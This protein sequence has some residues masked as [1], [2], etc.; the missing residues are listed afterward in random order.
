MK[1]YNAIW[2]LPGGVENYYSALQKILRHVEEQEPLQDQMIEDYKAL[3][4]TVNKDHVA[5]TQMLI[6]VHMGYVELS[7]GKY[8]LTEDGRSF[9]VQ[10]DSV[11]VYRRLEETHIGFQEI[12]LGLRSGCLSS[13]EIHAILREQVNP[14]WTT[15]AQ[16]SYRVNWLRSL[17][18][19]E[20]D[21]LTFKLMESGRKLS[22]EISSSNR[23]ST[24]RPESTPVS[25]KAPSAA[26]AI[27]AKL[28]DLGT[29]GDKWAEF[30][31]V[32][33]EAFEFLGFT[34]TKIGGSGEPDVVIKAPLGPKSYTV[35][36]D[37]KTTSH[38]TISTAQVNFDAILDHKK[39][40]KAQHVA[41]VAA[42]FSRGNL[43]KW[44]LERAVRLI[45]LD[46]L[47]QIILRHEATPFSLLDL[48][49]L[50]E[51]GGPLE[52]TSV[53]DDIVLLADEIEES[54]TLPMLIFR[55]LLEEQASC[56]AKLDEHSLYFLLD[57]EHQVSAIRE[58]LDFLR[59]PAI[60]AIAEDEERGL[61][62]RYGLS[63]F[64]GRLSRLMELSR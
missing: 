15:P 34:S 40:A 24:K 51:E 2:P 63:T 44:A 53:F 50:F 36:V 58:A 28:T 11:A 25:D 62:T 18:L 52:K 7:M 47:N 49:P 23:P 37:A 55:V 3:F 13:K 6:P 5:R 54:M 33:A 43:A 64:Q 16:P 4:P 39:K 38:S 60:A 27:T 12:L 32:V 30:E 17:E 26:E 14:G 35:V 41:I 57:K 61:S 42:G 10:P 29:S 45:D 21:G 8:R 1:Q 22:D 20:K 59:S 19:V 48:K 46:N 9:L 56:E 31:D